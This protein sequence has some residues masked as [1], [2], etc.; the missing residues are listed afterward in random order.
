M[1]F[2]DKK[3]EKLLRKLKIKNID[4]GLLNEALTHPSF[5]FERNI[6]N[7]P[8]YERLEFLG[9]SVLRLSL[10]NYLFDKYPDYQEGKLT[11]IRSYLVSDECLAKIASSIGLG[12]Y[13][14]IGKHEVKDGG[15][16]KESILACAMEALFGAIYKSLDFEA[17]KECIYSLYSDLDMDF[18]QILH[19]YNPKEILQQYTQGLNKD[20]PEYKVINEEGPAHKKIYNVGVFYHDE[21][22]GMGNAK[23]KKEAEKN[24]ALDALK[25][26]NIQEEDNN[27]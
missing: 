13:L 11:K 5:N 4:E 24:A 15:K 12:E 16:E 3:I 18:G 9:D 10:S 26:L 19:S 20:L 17:A 8:N 22:I 1:S 27:E 14:I 23:T 7:A 25:R 6:E 2:G 21:E